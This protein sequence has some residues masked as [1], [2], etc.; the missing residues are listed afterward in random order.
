MAW[1][2]PAS[3]WLEFVGF[4]LRDGGTNQV[5][6]LYIFIWFCR[7]KVYF[8]VHWRKRNSYRHTLCFANQPLPSFWLPLLCKGFAISNCLLYISTWVSCRRPNS[9]MCKTELL[10]AFLMPA[11]PAD[12]PI[13]V[14]SIIWLPSQ[15][16]LKPQNDLWFFLVSPLTWP[17]PKSHRHS[18]RNIYPILPSHPFPKLPYWLSSYFHTSY[19]NYQDLPTSSAHPIFCLAP[20]LSS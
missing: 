2:Q 19:L 1:S 6:S 8:C 7:A 20:G 15:L 9:R 12:S 14:T 11:Q 3:C 17:I 4:F 5:K 18:L 10:G 13:F 16:C